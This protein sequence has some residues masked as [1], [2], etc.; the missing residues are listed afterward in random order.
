MLV[1]LLTFFVRPVALRDEDLDARGYG[2]TGTCLRE[3]R[4]LAL[5][6]VSNGPW[7]LRG[8]R[9]MAMA[10]ASLVCSS[11]AWLHVFSSGPCTVRGPGAA[12]HNR[13]GVAETPLPAKT[14]G[15]TRAAVFN[16]SVFEARA[17][18]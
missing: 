6:E 8:S 1:L 17:G 5:A 13:W 4:L 3:V 15:R 2:S 16:V 18:F 11:L 7:S 10:R 9:G 12:G 14:R